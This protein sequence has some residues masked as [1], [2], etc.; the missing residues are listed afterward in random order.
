MS[1]I[2][3]PMPIHMVCRLLRACACVIA[4]EDLEIEDLAIEDLAFEDL[5]VRTGRL[6]KLFIYRLFCKLT[7]AAVVW[8]PGT[9]SCCIG[10]GCDW[11]TAIQ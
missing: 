10:H 4:I 9:F 6:R 5:R 2:S 7:C 11:L 1:A 8:L 3:H